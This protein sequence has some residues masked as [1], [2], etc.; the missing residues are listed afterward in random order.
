MSDALLSKEDVQE[1]LSKAF[2]SA[3][4]ARAHYA[5]SQKDFDR[6]GVD[7]TV[8]AGASFRP[9]ID[10]QLKATYRGEIKDGVIN[11]PCPVKNYNKLIIPTQTPRLLLLYRMP[12][13][14]DLWL[15]QTADNAMLR[16]GGYWVSLKGCDP[17]T[18][19]DSIT[20]QIPAENSMTVESL[21]KLMDKSRIG[22]L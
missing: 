20:I 4:A 16:H 3:I 19:S 18:N 9:K 11:Y 5:T 8:E 22:A 14:S 7:M 12:A 1:A 15:E 6:D 10:F 13:S 21:R 17:T 2:L